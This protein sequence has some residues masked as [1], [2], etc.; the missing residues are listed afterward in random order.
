MNLP[1]ELEGKRER[2][3]KETVILENG[4]YRGRMVDWVLVRSKTLSKC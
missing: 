2:T 3:G 1:V 4:I